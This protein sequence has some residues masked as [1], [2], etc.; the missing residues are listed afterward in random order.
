MFSEATE[1]HERF[2]RPVVSRALQG[3]TSS[4]RLN[5]GSTSR[6]GGRD[7]DS[8]RDSCRQVSR[9]QA[10]LDVPILP[11][12]TARLGMLQ[13]FIR[14]IEKSAL[15]FETSL[16]MTSRVRSSNL[17]GP[18]NGLLPGTIHFD[19]RIGRVAQIG[20]HRLDAET[21]FFSRRRYNPSTLSPDLPSVRQLRLERGCTDNIMVDESR[22]GQR[23]PKQR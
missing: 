12:A 10:A 8:P 7:L 2:A 15:N 14:S 1:A 23:M 20:C 19:C 11:T 9:S 16:D 13:F 4:G 18:S 22:I 21:F 5:S 3:S 17:P 6:N